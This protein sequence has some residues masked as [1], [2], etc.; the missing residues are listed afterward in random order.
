MA[1]IE[2]VQDTPLERKMKKKKR[3]EAAAIPPDTEALRAVRRAR[4]GCEIYKAC[5]RGS[6]QRGSMGKGESDADDTDARNEDEDDDAEAA[7]GAILPRPAA[8][9]TIPFVVA[10]I[11]PRRPYHYTHVVH[12]P[13]C[14]MCGCWASRARIAVLSRE[15]NPARRRTASPRCGGAAARVEDPEERVSGFDGSEGEREGAKEMGV[16]A[17]YCLARSWRRLRRKDRRKDRRRA[18][19][20]QLPR[21]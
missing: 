21:S 1:T 9:A 20:R 8:A 17:R 10:I 4:V 19:E 14:V 12:T 5:S 3:G 15:G 18:P 7:T 16:Y 6:A 13:Y 2:A 11:V